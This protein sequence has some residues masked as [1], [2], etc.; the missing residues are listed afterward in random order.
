MDVPTSAEEVSAAIALASPN[1]P[2]AASLVPSR[3]R[4]S[5]T[6]RTGADAIRETEGNARKKQSQGLASYETSTQFNGQRAEKHASTHC[7]NPIYM[8]NGRL[9][10]G[11]SRDI[12]RHRR[13][14][15]RYTQART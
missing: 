15:L 13:R 10:H 1:L 14:V 8:Q 6:T 11:I 12:C 5:T 3:H 7:K 9:N 4:S 2:V